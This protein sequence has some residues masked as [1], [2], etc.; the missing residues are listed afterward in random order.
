MLAKKLIKITGIDA[1][2]LLIVTD[3]TKAAALS[4][5][6]KG[7]DISV[8]DVSITTQGLSG[9]Q[10]IGDRL[11]FY[12][13]VRLEPSLKTTLTILVHELYHTNQDLLEFKG[14][15]YKKADANESYAYNLDYLFGEAFEVV[16]KTH[17]KKYSKVTH[18]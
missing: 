11:Q 14:I 10:E 17:H 15:K 1:N 6:R 12:C 4:L 5:N 18:E 8:S 7:F 13:I 16:V 2:V 9:Y 3:N